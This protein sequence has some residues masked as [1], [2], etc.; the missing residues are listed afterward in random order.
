MAAT[1]SVS[2]CI[3]VGRSLAVLHPVITGPS[4]GRRSHSGRLG[5][6]DGQRCR[7]GL[8]LGH[9]GQ[10]DTLVFSRGLNPLL[11]AGVAHS[12]SSRRAS[13]MPPGSGFGATCW[14]RASGTGLPRGGPD[15]AAGCARA[16][17]S[18]VVSISLASLF[19]SKDSAASPAGEVGVQTSCWPG[20]WLGPVSSSGSGGRAWLFIAVVFLLILR[21]HGVMSSASSGRPCEAEGVAAG[22]TS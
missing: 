17:S 20:G 12:T 13:S 10:C 8:I 21:D 7:V 1:P 19:A 22:T 3:G 14:D 4:L 11:K 5:W 15:G 16:W 6:P 9:Q 18:G 2:V